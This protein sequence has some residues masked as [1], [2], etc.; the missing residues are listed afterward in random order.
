MTK[1]FLH[2]ICPECQDHTWLLT[3]PGF[4]TGTC[5][6]SEKVRK[7][8]VADPAVGY[9]GEKHEIH[10]FCDLFLQGWK[11]GHGLLGSLDPLLKTN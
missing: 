1:H 3:V 4:L 11:G 7:K 2:K 8:P 6:I 5:D 9:G 10:L